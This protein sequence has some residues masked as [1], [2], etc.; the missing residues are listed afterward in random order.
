MIFFQ[1]AEWGRNGPVNEFIESLNEFHPTIKFTAE[2]SKKSM[3]VLNN[4]FFEKRAFFPWK[5]SETASHSL[6]I[7]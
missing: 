6:G 2:Y 3:Q 4:K 7:A 1:M 5:K